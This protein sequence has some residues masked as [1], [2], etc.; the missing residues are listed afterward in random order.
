MK[1]PIR[2]RVVRGGTRCSARLPRARHLLPAVVATIGIAAYGFAIP[3]TSAA[4]KSGNSSTLTIGLAAT[5]TSLNRAKDS[6]GYQNVMM[7]LAYETIIHMEPNGKFG[8]GLASSWRYVGKGNKTFTFTLR[9]NARFSDGS[10]VTASAVKSWLSYFAAAKGPFASTLSIASIATRGKW[11]V[12]I[13]LKASNP[14]VPYQLSEPANWGYVASAK[15]VARPTML[16]TQTD[17]AGPYVLVPSKTV[18]GD[19]YTFV[20]NKHFYDQSAIH[21]RQIVVKIIT[22][23]TTMLSALQSKQLDV[24]FGDPTT[25]AA[26]KS[27]HFGVVSAPAAVYGLFFLNQGANSPLGNAKVRQALNYAINRG[28]ITHA[29]VGKYGTP[30]SEWVTTDGYAPAYTN[31]YAYDPGTAKALLSSAG[32]AN[33]FSLSVVAAGFSGTSGV[34]LT[35]AV[36]QDLAAI[37]VHLNITTAPTSSEFVSDI[38]GGSYAM[39]E[40]FTA[41]SS[42][43]S[44]WQLMLSPQGIVNLQHFDDPVLDKLYATGSAA[45]KPAKYFQEMAARTVRQG[46]GLPVYDSDTFWYVSPQVRGVAYSAAAYMPFAAEWYPKG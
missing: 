26:A 33:G 1:Y 27:A 20:P 36:A 42:M 7:S 6:N 16:N 22:N 41:V 43:S 30:T 32:Y 31:Y 45:P 15:A 18:Q 8:P 21:Y 19:H 13:H 35:N 46:Y 25:V 17:G 24:A 39:A 10:A 38:F 11:T 40:N 44:L 29:L 3:A 5:P 2:A 34:N 23:P 9:H 12:T 37:G 14:N 28:A 4:K